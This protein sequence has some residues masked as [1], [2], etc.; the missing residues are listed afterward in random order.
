MEAADKGKREMVECLTKMA[1][2]LDLDLNHR[3]R[4]GANVLFY[5]VAGGHL[6]LL[7]FLLN[8][9]CEVTPDDH[10]RNLLMQAALSG[11]L[12]VVQFLV[13]QADRL[14][15]DIHHVDNNGRNALFYWWVKTV[16]WYYWSILSRKLTH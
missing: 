11:H 4:D 12:Q 5:C 9:G 7:K 8:A 13:R 14:G 15:I 16:T 6:N 2:T 3:D 10:G 1:A